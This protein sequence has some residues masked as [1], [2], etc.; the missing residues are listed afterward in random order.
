MAVRR[1]V[2][3]IFGERL[4]PERQDNPLVGRRHWFL[5]MESMPFTFIPGSIRSMMDYGG[6]PRE[7][8]QF[9]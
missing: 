7:V 6:A 2:A 3:K 1:S 9:F 5:R 4:E 8:E